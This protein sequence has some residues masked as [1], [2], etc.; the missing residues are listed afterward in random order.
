M[1]ALHFLRRLIMQQI[2]Y[3]LQTG[4]AS[5]SFCSTASPANRVTV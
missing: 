5:T 4:P 1:G 2:R 3:K